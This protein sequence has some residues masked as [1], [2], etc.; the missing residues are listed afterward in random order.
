MLI[1]TQCK[2]NVHSGK[3]DLGVGSCQNDGADD[4]FWGKAGYNW[5][6]NIYD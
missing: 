6:L 2:S 1:L 5:E 4:E 3:V